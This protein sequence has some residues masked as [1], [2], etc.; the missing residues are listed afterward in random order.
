MLAE[1]A[2]PDEEIHYVPDSCQV[3]LR[4]DAEPGRK[5]QLQLARIH[6]AAEVVDDQNV[7]VGEVPVENT[8]NQLRPG[9][10]GR[11]TVWGPRRPLIWN[12]LHKPWN[13]LVRS[14][15]M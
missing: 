8:D 2:I 4:L 9:M 10:A 5:R 3:T 12:L 15:G 14:L 1:I 7:F 11:A 13:L 6:P